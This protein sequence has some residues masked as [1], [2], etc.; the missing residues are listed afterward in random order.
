M[1]DVVKIGIGPVNRLQQTAQRGDERI[2]DAFQLGR[3]LGVQA[4]GNLALQR[5]QFK[6]IR[7]SRVIFIA[8]A[9]AVQGIDGFGKLLPVAAF[10]DID[11]RPL[12]FL[13]L[14]GQMVFRRLDSADGLTL[15]IVGGEA[16]VIAQQFRQM[17]EGGII[18][19]AQL[20]ITAEGLALEL[21][22]E[23]F[24]HFM[25]ASQAGGQSRNTDPR[26]GILDQLVQIPRLFAHIPSQAVPCRPTHR[27]N[28]PK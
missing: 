25:D 21:G 5:F 23:G 6:P 11:Q 2:F 19:R 24:N 28:Q 18:D 17:H 8:R 10:G 16:K 27:P 3:R 15:R 20:G 12:Q 4:A 22:Q 26:T 13:Q 9:N 14:V 1:F 7:R